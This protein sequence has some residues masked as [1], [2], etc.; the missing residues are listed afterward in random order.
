M[1]AVVVAALGVAIA[2]LGLRAGRYPR[3]RRPSQILLALKPV[4]QVTAVKATVAGTPHQRSNARPRT[5]AVAAA[6]AVV[7]ERVA[8]VAGQRSWIPLQVAGWLRM[9]GSSL[10]SLCGEM[11]VGALVGALLPWLVA[12]ATSV[13][14]VHLSLLI[15]IWASLVLASLGLV[16]P[17]VELRS[18][19]LRARKAARTV[20]AS[21]L[22][23]VVLCL[24]GG[25][26]VESALHS[27]AGVAIDPFSLSLLRVLELARD[28]GETPWWALAKFGHELGID[29]LVEL[30]AAIG[31][32]GSEGAR[33]RA[34]LAAKAASIR[35]HDLSQ[36][37]SEANTLTERLFIPG[38]LLLV[39]FLVFVGYPA[40]ARIASGF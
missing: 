5:R 39:G 19:A 8:T 18:D 13:L 24:A 32:A 10:E 14:A 16:A 34:T 23:L 17:M 26:G 40:V 29:E 20:L 7:G 11:A 38:A 12:V 30:S 22:D 3:R 21:Y 35:R 6:Q 36:A 4:E 27:A 15:P 31:L 37:E 33:V 2:L 25:M 28:S 1:T 9:S